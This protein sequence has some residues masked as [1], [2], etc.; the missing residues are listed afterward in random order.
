MFVGIWVVRWSQ[1]IKYLDAKTLLAR[2]FDL[3]YTAKWR[4]RRVV[5]SVEAKKM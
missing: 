2:V 1:S 5:S 3:L 4:E